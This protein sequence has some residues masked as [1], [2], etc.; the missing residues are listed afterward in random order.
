MSSLPRPSFHKI[1]LALFCS[2]LAF[3]SK[4]RA[5]DQPVNA[6]SIAQLEQRASQANPR[7]QCFLYTQIVHQMTHQASHEI[8]NGETEEAAGTLHQIDR[9]ARLIHA[10]LTRDAKRLKDA[11]ELMRNTTYRLAEVLHLTSG[12][13]RTS[14][15]QTLAQL[16]QVNDELLAQV[17]TH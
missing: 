1:S 7:E 8:A 15:E 3:T 16:N 4:A 17:F 9:Y 2:L 14:A 10:S 13:D 5:A 6:D 11:E 12:T